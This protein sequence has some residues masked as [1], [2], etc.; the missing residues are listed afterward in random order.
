[1]QQ[2]AEGVVIVDLE[3]RFLLSNEAAQRDRGDGPPRV[4]AR[5]VVLGLRVLPARQGDALPLRGAPPGPGHARRAR[6]RG[7]HLHPEPRARRRAPGSASTAARCA[8]T[9]TGHR[10]RDRL[11][12]RD[13]APPLPRGGADSSRRRSRRRPTPCSSRTSTPSSS[14]STPPSRAITGY[15]KDEAIGQ[16]PSILKSGQARAGLLRAALEVHPGRRGPQRNSRQQEEERRA[17]P[18]RADHH[19]DPRRRRQPHPLRLGDEGHHGAEERARSGRSRSASP[20]RCSR[21]STPSRAPRLRGLRPGRSRLRRG[22]HLRRL[23]RL[24]PHRRRPRRHRG[25]GCERPRLRPGP[26]HGGDAGLPPLARE[27]Q[28]R[29]RRDPEAAQPVPLQD[30]EDERF[31]TLLLALLD[32]TRR[33]LVYA[34][35]GHIPGYVLDALGATAA[36]LE[37]TGTP[38]GIF[39]EAEF[40]AS[41]EIPLAEGDLLLLLTDGAT[42]AQNE[43]G[44]F[45]E[46]RAACS[47]VWSRAGGPCSRPRSIQACGRPSRSSPRTAPARRH[48]R[49]RLQGPRGPVKARRPATG[50]AEK[51]CGHRLALGKHLSLALAGLRGHD[52]TLRRVRIRR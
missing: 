27:G 36:T 11:P 9:R 17:V 15:S 51:N 16:R 33:S 8:T 35:A 31:V 4:R 18:R 14:T 48:H 32:P 41:A 28:H 20:G 12:R 30:T 47:E 52:H 34:S 22:P 7:G 46:S 26:A 3:G 39:E 43:D 42:E 44:D 38:L 40:P 13:G 50:L 29:P 25:R 6:A 5:R 2:V 49:R 19:T 10:R 21:S 23:L 37:P 1:M 45:F 24:H